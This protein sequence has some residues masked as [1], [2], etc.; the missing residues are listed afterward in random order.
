M[1]MP[2]FEDN[3]TTAAAELVDRPRRRTFTARDKLRILDEL[4]RAAGPPGAIGAILRREG[5]Y[6]SSLV[7]WR[8]HR[9]S[10]GYGALIPAKRGPKPAAANPL[11]ADHARFQRDYKRL[12][13][14]L[15][16]AEAVIDI[17]KKSHFCRVCRS[18]ATRSHVGWAYRTGTRFKRRLGSLQSAW[19]VARDLPSSQSR[20]GTTLC[21][22]PSTTGTPAEDFH[23]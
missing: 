11:A 19:A 1:G 20:G 10:G 6:P 5:V 3:E 8:R 4:D 14:R 17:Q 23:I 15:Q 21:R 18:T 9:A 2:N 12:E 22:C 13:Q 7:E 16:R